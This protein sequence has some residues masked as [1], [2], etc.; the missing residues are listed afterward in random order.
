MGKC[1]DRGAR[2]VG[3][4]ASAPPLAFSHSSGYDVSTGDYMLVANAG[5]VA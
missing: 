3:F 5:I 2:T 1:G 4:A